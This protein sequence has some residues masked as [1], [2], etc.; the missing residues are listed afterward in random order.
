[1][2]WERLWIDISDK[3]NVRIDGDQ[4]PPHF[5]GAAVLEPQKR[6]G[7]M[8]VESSN[9]IDGQQRFTTL[10]YFLAGLAIMLRQ[11]QQTSLLSLV[12]RCLWNDNPD[13]MRQPEL[14]K[15]KV[16]PTFR[17]RSDFQL[18][19]KA[20]SLQELRVA[21]PRSFTQ[22]GTLKKI[23]VDHP[24]ALE[25]IW[26]FAGQIA[27]WALS[28]PN[29]QRSARLRAMSEAVL[30]DLRL[31]SISLGNEDDAQVIFETLN[32]HGAQLHATDL[33]RNFIFMRAD[34]DG[35]QGHALFDTYWTQ[36]ESSFWAEQQ[37]RGRLTKP[38]MEWFLQSTLQAALGEEVE[39]G[40]LYAHYRNFAL[41]NGPAIKAA[42]Q[43]QML[44][45]YAGH[46]RQLISGVGNDPIA[47][48][49]RRAAAWDASTVH[50]LA[51]R[52]ASAELPPNAQ[53]NLYDCLVS[54]F[55]RRA[56][57][58]LP[59]KNYNKTFIQLLRNLAATDLAPELLRSALA[60]PK[61]DSSRWPS[62]EEFRKA[63]L[64][65]A[66]YPGALD[67]QQVKAVLAEIENGMRTAR[68][69]EPI[70]TGLEH[71]DVDHILPQS[72]FQ[73]WKLPDGTKSEESEAS[74]LHL[75]DL[76]GEVLTDRQSMIYRRE[77]DKV[78]MGN[79]T[80]LHYGINR[81]LQNREFILKRE[82]LFAESN[83]HLNR[84]I[85]RLDDWDETHIADRGQ[86][87]FDVALK[88]WR[89]P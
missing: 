64:D 49:G 47:T 29:G 77:Q 5:L 2:K 10:Q 35:A 42:E 76:I 75:A 17:D 19:L 38:R 40:R 21:F 86:K 52:I 89:G 45:R 87:M 73:Y 83:L 31:V 25:A 84:M 32:G 54:Y 82:K 6:S 62:D 36:F 85:M 63:W 57:C 44:D 81:S 27:E 1:V 3:A 88:L 65:N 55:V 43:L 34:S 18:A 22:N 11:E 51:L 15:F 72:W 7:L 41:P 30:S 23:G 69:E 9:I 20:T 46:Y 4:P 74:G 39:I 13:T 53:S 80:L 48:F 24:P 12:E 70:A 56:I 78:T 50:P 37:R 14:E 67:A 8:G 66:I 58:G 79:L 68:T 16:W 33:I 26:Y 71:L 61:A 60:S 59:T 28:A